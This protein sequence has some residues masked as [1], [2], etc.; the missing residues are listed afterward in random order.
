MKSQLFAHDAE[1]IWNKMKDFNETKND[2]YRMPHD[3]KL[4]VNDSILFISC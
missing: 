2:A 3:G 1:M 4:A